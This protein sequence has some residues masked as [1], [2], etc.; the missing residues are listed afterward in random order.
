M[1]LNFGIYIYKLHQYKKESCV[2]T[3]KRR[4]FNFLCCIFPKYGFYNSELQI[5]FVPMKFM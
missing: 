5:I 3:F 1:K 2:K 4:F